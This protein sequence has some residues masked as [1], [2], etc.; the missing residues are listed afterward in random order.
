MCPYGNPHTTEVGTEPG[1]VS[2]VGYGIE[3]HTIHVAVSWNT[4][5]PAAEGNPTPNPDGV[6]A[7]LYE[8]KRTSIRL[9]SLTLTHDFRVQTY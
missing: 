1:L 5:T 3:I 8:L 2:V 7:V 4:A 6:D 9:L